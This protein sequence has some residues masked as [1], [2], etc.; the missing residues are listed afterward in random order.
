MT[1][2]A[3]FNHWTVHDIGDEE[4]GVALDDADVEEQAQVAA[5]DLVCLGKW[6][7]TPSDLGQD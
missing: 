5:G 2:R 6:D 7:D 1:I 4:Q 3:L